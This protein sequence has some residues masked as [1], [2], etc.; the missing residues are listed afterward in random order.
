MKT[1]IDLLAFTTIC[2]IKISMIVVLMLL[3]IYMVA[4]RLIKGKPQPVVIQQKSEQEI[5]E[6]ECP[7]YDEVR[8]SD[9]IDYN[10]L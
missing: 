9:Y 3:A 1:I 2:L 6:E 7:D 10:D 8:I 5:F 4:Y